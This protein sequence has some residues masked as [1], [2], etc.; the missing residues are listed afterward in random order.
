[1]L[2]ALSLTA[3][4]AGA[5][6]A[7][8]SLTAP[9]I[10]SVSTPGILVDDM[11]LAA[12]S[13]HVKEIDQAKGLV[14]PDRSC[15]PGAT[16]PAVT[17]ENL[18]ATICRAG[19]TATVRPSAS[20]T[21]PAKTASLKAYGLPY[22]PTTEYDHVIPLEL[23]GATATSNLWPE[24]NYDGAAGTTNPKDDVENVLNRAVCSGKVTLAAAQQAI[25]S[26]W[27]TAKAKLG[28]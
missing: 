24:P 11:H 19:Y 7:V 21:N 18:K 1:L 13:C 22:T 14:L 3:C 8:N 23:G 12:G 16:D 26:D 20:V 4:A 5:G 25:A 15:S 27:T 17:Q 6:I 2:A 28:L 10:H 9:S